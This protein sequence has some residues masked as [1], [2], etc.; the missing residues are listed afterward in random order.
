MRL[1]E[2]NESCLGGKTVRL[3]SLVDYGGALHRG[4]D[5]GGTRDLEVGPILRVEDA[6]HLDKVIR[7]FKSRG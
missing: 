6:Q 7:L 1:D 3:T 2:Y 4:F 5:N